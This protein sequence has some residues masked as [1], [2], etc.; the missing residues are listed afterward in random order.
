MTTRP[1][2]TKRLL[3]SAPKLSEVPA[4]FEFLGDPQAMQYTQCDSDITKCRRRIAV[5]EW[6]RRTLGYAPWTVR[7]KGENKVIG[8][9]GLYDD[10]FDPGWGIE[11]VYYFAPSVWGNGY[12]SELCEVAL[13]IADKHLQAAKVS[14]FAHPKNTASDALLMRVGF[15]YQRFIASMNRNLY[16]RERPD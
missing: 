16:S 14:A 4:L 11:L 12:G 8:W 5:H 7:K 2:E 1:L 13:E 3:L 6:Q 10:P 15:K 9:G